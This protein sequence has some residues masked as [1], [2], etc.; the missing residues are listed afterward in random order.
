MDNPGMTHNISVPERL[1]GFFSMLLCP[2]VTAYAGWNFVW[3]RIDQMPC[4]PEM[5][6]SIV[7]AYVTAVLVSTLCWWLAAEF[8]RK[9]SIWYLQLKI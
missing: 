8:C 7:P 9:C 1:L 2:W 5:H 6:M 4:T 3:Q